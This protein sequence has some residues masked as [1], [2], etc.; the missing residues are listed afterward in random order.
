MTKTNTTKT[1]TQTQVEAKKDEVA[2]Y[3]ETKTQKELLTKYGNKSQAIRALAKEGHKT[4]EI[5][6]LLNIRYQHVRNV[7]NTIVKKTA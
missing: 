2:L 4:A 5:A 6:R 1:A 7:L 3:Q